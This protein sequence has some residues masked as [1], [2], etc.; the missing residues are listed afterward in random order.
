[1]VRSLA[2]GIMT[3]TVGNGQYNGEQL[4]YIVPNNHQTRITLMS[5]TNITENP[6]VPVLF[7][8]FK[9]IGTLDYVISPNNMVLPA[10]YMAQE[11]GEVT[12][13]VELFNLISMERKFH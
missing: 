4:L 8:L 9:N 13:S 12:L 1:M 6:G 11:D 5:F 10:Q 3:G 2:S 7:T